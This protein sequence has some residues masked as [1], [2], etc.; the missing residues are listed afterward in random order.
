MSNK[1]QVKQRGFVMTGGGAK[2]LY[3]AGVIHAFHLTGME[4]DVITGSSIGAMNSL[5]YA[6]YLFRKRQ[7]P[8]AVRA[9]ALQALERMDELVKAYHRAWLLLPDKRVIDDS[10]EGPL[11][12][13]KDD[14]LRFN[15]SVPQVTRLAWWWTDPDRRAL[16]PP[17]M[18]PTMLRLLTELAERLGGAGTMLRLMRDHPRGFVRE[19]LRTYL[20]RFRL[21]RSLIPEGEDNKLSD[22]F[23]K[24]VAPLR[25]EHLEGVVNAPDDPQARTYQ[26]V[27]PGRTLRDYRQ[28]GIE[29]RLTRANYRTGRL[30][31][32]AYVPAQAFARFLNKHAWRIRAKGPEKIPLGSFRLQV[33]GNPVAI[34][35]ALCSGRF[36]GV[37]RPYRLQDLYPPGDADNALL[38]RLLEGWLSDPAA[39]AALKPAFQALNAGAARGEGEWAD[40]RQSASMRQFFPRPGDAYV[41]GGAIDN[42]PYT[43][44]VDYVREGVAE[45][46]ASNRAVTLEL[47]VIYLGAEP[48]VKQDEAS[49]PA[50][51]EVV[52]RTLA[53]VGAAS[54]TRGAH[55]FDTINTFG[56]RA[57]QLGRVLEMVLESYQ[58][59]LDSLEPAARARAEADLRERAR[60]LGLRGFLGDSPKEILNR[61]RDWT[62]EAIATGLPLHVEAVKIYPE[63]MPLGTLQFTERLGYRQANAI[64]MLTMGCYNTLD[65]L[66]TRLEAAGWEDL[67]EHDRRALTL[68]RT[69]TGDAWQPA[70]PAAPEASRPL[71]RCQRT[72]CAFHARACRHG[73]A[74]GGNAGNGRL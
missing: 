23:T 2:G 34:N 11:G 68:A 5:F 56:R 39:E 47:Y 48:Q 57:E 44:A 59:T 22:V 7:L 30:E 24:S 53:M 65:T 66:R 38:Y 63:R 54:E 61:M 25:P 18:W 19:A 8:E 27:D 71:W 70:D 6:E 21:D 10:A 13:L 50:I 37:F 4:F 42:T 35:A 49:D 31:L 52:S 45:S 69:W 28:A 20:E 15:L 16:P 40:W 36:P 67:D 32:S 62:A 72:A 33:P 74:A 1:S 41:D 3:E 73:A 55:T 29:V 17:G 60:A 12:Q 64:E 58:A 26:L 51:F 43:S 14:L 9:D 46:S